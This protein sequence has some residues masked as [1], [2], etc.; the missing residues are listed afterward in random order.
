V[1]VGTGDVELVDD[2]V[3]VEELVVLVDDDVEVEE[4]VVLLD[5]VGEAVV[6]G[7]PLKLAVNVWLAAGVVIVW[8]LA[9]PS[10]HDAKVRVLPPLVCGDGVSIERPKP[11]TPVMLDG[12]ASG[13]PSSVTWRPLGA[14]ANVITERTGSI[15]TDLVAVSPSESLA[16][17]MI[18]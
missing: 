3:E 7:P 5:V 6:V 9:P 14:V 4:L 15:I 16:L 2:D 18:S 10:D 1:V 17:R 11:T 8:L 13:W 12:V